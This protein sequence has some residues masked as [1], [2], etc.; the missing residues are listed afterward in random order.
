MTIIEVG[1]E[2]YTLALSL[3]TVWVCTK[4]VLA[5]WGMRG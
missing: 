1:P 4:L 2:L 3:M 5:W